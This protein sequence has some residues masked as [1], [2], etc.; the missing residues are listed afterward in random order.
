[1]DEFQTIEPT[2][3]AAWR[4]DVDGADVV[5]FA[6]VA[7]VVRGATVSLF[8]ARRFPVRAMADRQTDEALARV[9]D[10][11]ADAGDGWRD[12][13]VPVVVMAAGNARDAAT[14][15]RAGVSYVRAGDGGAPLVS[16]FVASHDGNASRAFDRIRDAV[17]FAVGRPVAP[18]LPGERCAPVVASHG[19]AAPTL[20]Q[21]RADAAAGR[22]VSLA[23]LAGALSADAFATGDRIHA[24]ATARAARVR[25]M[26]ANA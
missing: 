12:D 7:D 21:L 9:C 25:A 15:Q 2:A 6:W 20:P 5:P 17:A 16:P 1:M 24:T 13:V 18:C 4:A 23:A 19:V 10:A 22:P 8:D 3:T 26:L 14:L 11:V